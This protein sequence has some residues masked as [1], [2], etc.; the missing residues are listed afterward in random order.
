MVRVVEHQ[1]VACFL[2]GLL[3]LGAFC[4]ALSH[5]RQQ[6]LQESRPERE[7]DGRGIF[8]PSFLPDLRNFHQLRHHAE[9]TLGLEERNEAA[10]RPVDG[11]L[12]LV[13]KNKPGEAHT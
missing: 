4:Q 7:R 11:E 1:H 10:F 3:R 8:D 9:D 12:I 5:D 13:S 6:V 2:E